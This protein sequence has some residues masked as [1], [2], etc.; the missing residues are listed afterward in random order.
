M[1]L[2]A[3]IMYNFAFF[4]FSLVF[5]VLIFVLENLRRPAGIATIAE[6]FDEKILASV[7]SIESQL[8]SVIGAIM[9][10]VIGLVADWFGPGLAIMLVALL[11]LVLYPALRIVK[12]K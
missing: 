5:F 10:L 7:L 9:S 11:I 12:I 3:G 6:Q 1:G 4:G 2:V 8:S